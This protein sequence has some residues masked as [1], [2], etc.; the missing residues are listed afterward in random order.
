MTFGV[1]TRTSRCPSIRVFGVPEKHGPNDESGCP[2][3]DESVILIHFSILR[4]VKTAVIEKNQNFR[5]TVLM[6]TSSIEELAPDK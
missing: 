3:G 2:S 5:D 6:R 4:V 1:L